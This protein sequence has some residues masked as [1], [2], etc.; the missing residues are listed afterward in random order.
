MKGIATANGFDVMGLLTDG[1]G[2]RNAVIKAIKEAADTLKAGDI[3]LYTYAGH[4]SQL[5][6]FNAEGEAT[7]VDETWCLFDGMFLDDEAYELWTRF[8]EGV[9]VLVFLDSCHSGTA[10]RN[11]PDMFDRG[12]TMSTDGRKPRLLPLSVAARAFQQQSGVL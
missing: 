6:D 1:K 9:R 8:R 7:S 3:F 12:G 5:P 2:T 4:G 10:I 11:A